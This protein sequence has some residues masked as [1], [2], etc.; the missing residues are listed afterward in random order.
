MFQALAMQRW[1]QPGPKVAQ[2]ACL[3]AFLN[4]ES[5]FEPQNTENNFVDYFLTSL[6]K[7]TYVVSCWMH[8]RDTN[9][10]HKQIPKSII[11]VKTW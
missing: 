3:T 8:G 11:Q 7:G 2:H 9:S 1:E 6:Q 10:L 5:V 4:W